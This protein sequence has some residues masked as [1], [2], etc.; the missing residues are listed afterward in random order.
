MKWSY[1]FLLMPLLVATSCFYFGRFKPNKGGN[2][3]MGFCVWRI[4]FHILLWW[5]TFVNN[6][7]PNQFTKK[8]KE[9]FQKETRHNQSYHLTQKELF[10]EFYQRRKVLLPS[11]KLTNRHGKSPPFLENTIKM[12]DLPASYV[13]LQECIL[14]SKTFHGT[15]ASQPV[16]HVWIDSWGFRTMEARPKEKTHHPLNLGWNPVDFR[17]RWF[18]PSLPL[19]EWLLDSVRGFFSS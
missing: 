1:R 12:V 15:S 13:S 4:S 10:P 16:G 19:Q 17:W 14:A 6:N 11:L 9:K 5:K 3:C 18:F 7:F 2:S 8:V